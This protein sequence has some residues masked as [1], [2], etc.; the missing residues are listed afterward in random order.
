MVKR[1]ICMVANRVWKMKPK[2]GTKR[3]RNEG[4]EKKKEKGK[5]NSKKFWF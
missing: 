3:E 2:K 1:G 5:E 4:K